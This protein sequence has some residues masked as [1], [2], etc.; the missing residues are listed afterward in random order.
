MVSAVLFI[1]SKFSQLVIE[2][3]GCYFPLQIFERE[4][5]FLKSVF[6]DKSATQWLMKNIKHIVDGFSSIQFFTFRDDD[7]IYILQRSPNSFGQFL[8]LT[9]L[10]VGRSRRSVIIPEG[11]G[12]NGWRTFGL[13]LRKTLEPNQYAACGSGHSKFVAQPHRCN[14]EIQISNHIQV[15]DRKH[16]EQLC[17]KDMRKMELAEDSMVM[18]NPELAKVVLS[19]ESVDKLC[20]T[21]VGGGFVRDNPCRK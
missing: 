7:I 9:E 5:Y 11:R 17:I 10:K 19:G 18:P 3:G 2:E 13:E 12:K 16:P 15:K 21:A 8:L 4:N 14:L 6:M 20:L 1:E